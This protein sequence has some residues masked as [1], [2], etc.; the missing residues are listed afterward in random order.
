LT[1]SGTNV[2]IAG[3]PSPEFCSIVVVG[4]M[5]PAIHHPS[6]Y[7]SMKLLNDKERD[8]AVAGPLVIMQQVSQF[9]A[10]DFGIVCVPNR[11][12]IQT[13]KVASMDRILDVASRVFEILDHTPVS[14]F[15]FNFHFH[16]ETAVERI[17]DRLAA[18]IKR[19]PLGFQLFD[20]AEGQ[21]VITSTRPNQKKVVTV[22]Q[23]VLGTN[24]AFIGFNFHYEI[25]LTNPPSHFNLTSLFI[26]YFRPDY[27][28]SQRLSKDVTEGL[29]KIGGV[30]AP[31][32]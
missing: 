15:G 21:L 20:N 9:V 28:E 17:G 13:Q 23:S 8:S 31:S 4:M 7:H 25:A 5:N 29:A 18:T 27:D 32:N 2:T 16:R 11:W 10:P 22:A 14:A 19:L 1:E 26:E 6:W 24:R 3:Q 12:E 30:S